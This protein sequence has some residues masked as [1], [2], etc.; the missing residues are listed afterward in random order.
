MPSDYDN[1]LLHEAILN[2]KA[3]D[4]AMARHYLERALELADDWDTRTQANFYMS[5]LADD[6]AQ[7]RQ[8][9][10]ETLALDPTHIEA[11][12]A[13]AILDGK[14][15]PEDIVDADH[16]P[17][18]ATETHNATAN[19]FVCPKCGSRMV[20]DGDGRT[21]VCESCA[22][23]ETLSSAHPQNEQ[24]FIVAMANGQGQRRPVAM[25]TF[26]C[27]GCGARFLLPPEV[28]SETCSYCGSVYVL[29]GTAEL[30][31]PDSIIPL[32]FNQHEAALHLVEWVEKHKI[33]PQGKVRAP[34]GLYMPVW[35]FDIMG[36]VPW[37]GTVHRNKQTVHVSGDEAAGFDAIII[38]ASSKLGDLFQKALKEYAF[39]SASAYDPRYLA[40]WPAE[41]YEMAMAPASLEARGRV[42]DRIKEIIHADTPGVYDLGYSTS[43]LSIL[44]FKLVLVP[45]W[46]TEYSLED[47]IFRVLINGQNGAV[48]GETPSHGILDWIGNA[49][50]G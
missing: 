6:P 36:D 44:S 48:Y 1:D 37:S 28:I 8:Y 24:D 20:F 12:R 10:E 45:V 27:Q 11:R 43:G 40:G 22:R 46:V 30:V 7:K 39:S 19:R 23:Q 50:G 42:V 4:F 21:L 32:A 25:N 17:V 2:I 3:R 26:A 35:T 34:R 5:Q 41:I 49:L 14:L 33:T 15:K 29:A 47:H 13:L 31:E 18:Q 9:L 38:P 16:L